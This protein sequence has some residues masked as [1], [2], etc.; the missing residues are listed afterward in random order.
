M[1]HSYGLATL[2]GRNEERRVIFDDAGLHLPAVDI[3]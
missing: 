1:H 3:G 2:Q